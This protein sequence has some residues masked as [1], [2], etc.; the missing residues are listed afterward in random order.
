[1]G[2]KLKTKKAAAKRFKK[3][4]ATGK[5]VRG[6]QGHGHF[7]SKD[8]QKARTG[9][10]TTLVSDADF[11]MVNNLLPYANAKRKRTKALNRATA[12]AKAEGK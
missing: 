10:G 11:N 3:S 9:A 4:T 2:Y 12:A 6:I 7:L 8:G 5:I 1:M